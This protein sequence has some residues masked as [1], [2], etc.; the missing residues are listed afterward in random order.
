MQS[1]LQPTIFRNLSSA[2]IRGVALGWRAI[3]P[4]GQRGLHASR[5][6]CEE[7]ARGRS[8]HRLAGRI[9]RPDP[10]PHCSSLP[11]PCGR[12]GQGRAGRGAESVGWGR[13]EG[14]LAGRTGPDSNRGGVSAGRCGA[15]ASRGARPAIRPSSPPVRQSAGSTGGYGAGGDQSGRVGSARLAVPRASRSGPY[16]VSRR[17][18]D[19]GGLPSPSGSASPPAL[20]FVG[21]YREGL[22]GPVRTHTS[23][24]PPGSLREGH[25]TPGRVPGV[26]GVGECGGAR[27][28]C[29]SSRPWL[30]QPSRWSSRRVLLRGAHAAR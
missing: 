11:A 19:A 10:A 25:T 27:A 8:T 4:F 21:G 22:Y 14:I 7:R 5:P 30:S 3:A 15:T 24:R 1:S 18:R 26:P 6:R 2:P 28:S 9:P 13:P 23:R 17:P 12:E 16:R 29:V 20:L